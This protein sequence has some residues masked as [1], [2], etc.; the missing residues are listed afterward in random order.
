MRRLATATCPKYMTVMSPNAC[1]SAVLVVKVLRKQSPTISSHGLTSERSTH[2]PIT[3]YYHQRGTLS[4]ALTLACEKPT[5]GRRPTKPNS[6][7]ILALK[8]RSRRHATHAL[9]RPWLSRPPLRL[10]C[11]IAT[12]RDFRIRHHGLGEPRAGQSDQEGLEYVA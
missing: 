7:T 8:H 9:P 10:L 5:K 4:A 12:P 3:A 11:R 1:V 6:R 2:W